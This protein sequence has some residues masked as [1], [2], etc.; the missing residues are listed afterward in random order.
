MKGCHRSF[1]FNARELFSIRQ[2]LAT[3]PGYTQGLAQITP[4]FNYKIVSM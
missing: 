3:V 1:L 4:C 2:V